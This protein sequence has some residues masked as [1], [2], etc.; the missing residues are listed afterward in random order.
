MKLRLG[1]YISAGAVLLIV[2]IL[3]QSFSS[4]S[5]TNRLTNLDALSILT[6]TREEGRELS[7]DEIESGQFHNLRLR[8]DGLSCLTCTD[9]VF[10][11]LVNMIGIVNAQVR[12]GSS[13]IIYDGG[14]LDKKEILDSELFTTGVY[15]AMEQDDK[16]IHR[17]EDAEC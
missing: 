9:T 7:Q 3:F 2:V 14:E 13:C 6:Q 10:Y 4:S 12:Q 5:S 16:V 17:K 11:G 15:M 8:I 1:H